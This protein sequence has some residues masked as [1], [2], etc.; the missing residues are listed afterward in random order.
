MPEA[1]LTIADTKERKRKIIRYKIGLFRRSFFF[2]NKITD[3]RSR[4]KGKGESARG[5]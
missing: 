4:A 1:A 2:S 5:K 3:M